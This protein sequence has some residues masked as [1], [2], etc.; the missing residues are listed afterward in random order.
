MTV[1]PELRLNPRSSTPLY[2]QVSN[3]VRGLIEDGRLPNA[4]VLPAEEDLAAGWAV[5]RD[6]VRRAFELLARDGLLRRRRGSG[7]TV[8]TPVGCRAWLADKDLASHIQPVSSARNAV[9]LRVGPGRSPDPGVAAVLGVDP[10]DDVL[11]AV[12]LTYEAERP[13]AI[14]YVWRPREL[15]DP[16][17]SHGADRTFHRL[18]RR[19]QESGSDFEDVELDEVVR[20]APLPDDAAVAL[21]VSAGQYGLLVERHLRAGGRTIEVRR[22]Y[23]PAAVAGMRRVVRAAVAK[24]E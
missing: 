8:V 23:T 22:T 14:D 7:T 2:W 3:A 20:A 10:G 4:F 24:E 9:T 11:E 17:A 21:G 19:V 13:V 15:S 6:T 1:V 12:S 16:D 18:L 5:S